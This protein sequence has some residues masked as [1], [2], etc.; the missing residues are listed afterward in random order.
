MKPASIPP[1]DHHLLGLLA[2]GPAHGYDL[3]AKIESAPYATDVV[4]TGS[5]ATYQALAAMERQGWICGSR[6]KAG[7]RQF[8]TSYELTQAGQNALWLATD[9]ALREPA[10]SPAFRRGIA[11]AQVLSPG[12]VASRITAAR[13][14]VEALQARLDA[15][16]PDAPPH[17]YSLVAGERRMTE[18]LIACLDEWA[19]L[20]A[21][22]LAEA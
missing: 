13:A 15:P 5:V 16:D 7:T 14:Q 10:A 22:P 12:I 9:Q 8:R 19:N 1:L 11:Y 2:Q 3:L 18:V 20:L 17:R 6:E 4:D 21:D